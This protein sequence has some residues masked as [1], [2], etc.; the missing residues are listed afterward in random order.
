MFKSLGTVQAKLTYG[1][2]PKIW[3]EAVTLS[4]DLPLSVEMGGLALV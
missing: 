4:A 2:A 1:E 3:V